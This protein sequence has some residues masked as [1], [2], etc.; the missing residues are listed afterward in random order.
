MKIFCWG[1]LGEQECILAE[2]VEEAYAKL[3]DDM[4]EYGSY[5]PENCKVIEITDGR[6][7]AYDIWE[8]K[9]YDDI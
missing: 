5:T 3:S 8:Y 1:W 9:S 7:C 6:F 2:T 4:L